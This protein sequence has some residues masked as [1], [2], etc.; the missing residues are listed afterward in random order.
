MVD[1]THLIAV[2]IGAIPMLMYARHVEKK[3][4]P[5]DIHHSRTHDK[6]R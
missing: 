3:Y 6:A 4:K 5:T 2:A 1:I